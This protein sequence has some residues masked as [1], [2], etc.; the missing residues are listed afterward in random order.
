MLI[1]TLKILKCKIPPEVKFD[2]KNAAG[3][4]WQSAVNTPAV[5]CNVVGGLHNCAGVQSFHRIGV[6]VT[7]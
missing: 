6:Q 1:N 5:P 2:L 3:L 4:P 7:K